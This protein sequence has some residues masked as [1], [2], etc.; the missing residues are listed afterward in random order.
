MVLREGV[1]TFFL[2]L[3]IPVRKKRNYFYA[4]WDVGVPKVS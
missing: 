2:F 4:S 3:I 1:L